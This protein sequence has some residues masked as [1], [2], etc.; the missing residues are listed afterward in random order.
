MSQSNPGKRF[1][2]LLEGSEGVVIPAA[3]DVLSARI[4]EEAGF[5]TVLLSG[6]G[7]AASHLGVPDLGIISYSEVAAMARNT[8]RAVSIPVIADVDTG[9][10][11]LQNLRRT[12]EDFEQT[13]IA[14]IQLEDQAMPKQCGHLGVPRVIEAEEMVE[15]IA[16]VREARRSSDFHLIA[17]TDALT[18]LGFDEALRRGKMYAEAGADA[19]FIEAPQDVEQVRSIPKEIPAPCVSIVVEGGKSPMLDAAELAEMGY[20]L[21][22]F[23]ATAI[24]S[25]ATA[26]AENLEELR[27]SGS[28][29][30]IA[31]RVVGFRKIQELVGLADCK[32]FETKLTSVESVSA[33]EKKRS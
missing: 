13:G 26:M 19:I 21:L 4:I 15:K 8:A 9:F 20:R 22:Y 16:A 18:P 29:R 31:E 32:S 5:E 3:Y 25:A 7:I 14:A 33:L 28:V 17:R 30:K 12:V 23:P 1:R 6:S 10:G 2:R 27:R 24:I 11:G